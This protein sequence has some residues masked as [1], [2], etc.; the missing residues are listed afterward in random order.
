[1]K[2]TNTPQPFSRGDRSFLLNPLLRGVAEI[3][4]LQYHSRGVLMKRKVIPYDSKLKQLARKLRKDSTLGE[5]LLWNELKSKHLH[6]FDFHRQKP[7]LNYIADFYCH[8]LGLIIEID[9]RYHH[10]EE[11]YALD[12][13]REDDLA[14]HDLTI[15][16]FTEME[17]RNDMVN[18]LRTIETYVLEKRAS[19]L[20]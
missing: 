8:E 17:V 12:C 5:V 11:Q 16:R 19:G 18:V 3:C 6:G 20:A 1:M 2:R 15:I 10:N 14:R 7:L 4:N 9:G 13:L